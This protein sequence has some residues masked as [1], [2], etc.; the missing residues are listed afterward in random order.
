MLER[1]IL[2]M[3][4]QIEILGKSSK[5]GAIRGRET[6][7][8]MSCQEWTKQTNTAVRVVRDV[9]R[10]DTYKSQTGQAPV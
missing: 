6:V 5:A 10:R 3:M 8:I 1:D 2:K 9:L 7:D 4:L